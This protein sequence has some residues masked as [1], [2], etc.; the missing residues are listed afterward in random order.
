MVE[1]ARQG[2]AFRLYLEMGPMRS[3]V[4]LRERIKADQQAHGF[5]K[6]PS[7]RTL[8]AW[9]SRHSWPA[10]IAKIEQRAQEEEEQEYVQKVKEYRARLRQEGIL[11]QQKGLTWLQAKD[12]DDVRALDA[13]RAIAEGFRLEALGLGEATDRIAVKKDYADV[14]GHLSDDELRRLAELL[15]QGPAPRAP[16]AGE[17]PS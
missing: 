3:L 14:F 7:L 17:A 2:A 10:R 13:V 16:G 5:T 11:L 8:D 4:R 9:S 6:V 1:S 12:A 15:R